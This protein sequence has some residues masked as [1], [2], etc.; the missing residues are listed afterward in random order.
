MASS[1]TDLRPFCVRLG[2]HQD[3]RHPGGVVADL[4]QPLELDVLKRGATAQQVNAVQWVSSRTATAPTKQAASPNDG[5]ADEEHVRLRVAER[6]Q[7]VVVFLARRIPEPQVDRPVVHHDVGAVVVE[8]RRDV[9][10]WECVGRSPAHSPDDDT[11][12]VL[13]VGHTAAGSAAELA[14][15]ET[16]AQE[17]CEGAASAAIAADDHG[18]VWSLATGL[19]E[20]LVDSVDDFHLLLLLRSSENSVL[21]AGILAVTKEEFDHYDIS[22]GVTGHG[23]VAGVHVVQVEE[24]AV[25]RE[26]ERLGRRGG[27]GRRRLGVQVGADAADA[28]DVDEGARLQQRRGELH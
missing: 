11:L 24:D 25:G 13:H 7:P 2:A 20:L 1:N 17:C 21:R 4:G 5:E 28:A 10:A 12:H 19:R 8:D 3:K 16:D 15:C 22:E 18:G 23:P 26:L 27:Q 9:L 6:T 14:V